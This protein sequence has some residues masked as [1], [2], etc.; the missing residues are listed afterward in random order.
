MGGRLRS[1]FN[2]GKMERSMTGITMS[3]RTRTKMDERGV[4]LKWTSAGNLAKRKD[5]R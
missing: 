2:H 5:V 3:D 4:K 1:I